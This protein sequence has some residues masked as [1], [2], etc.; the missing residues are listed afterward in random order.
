MKTAILFLIYNRVETSKQV[1]E[2][3]KK[4]EP[5]RL[6]I[7]GDGPKINKEGDADNVKSVRELVLNGITW[8]CEV[9]TL[10]HDSNL[11]CKKAVDGA[12]KWF[13]TKEKQGIIL[14]DDC[15]PLPFFFTFCEKLLGMY[16]N[17]KRIASITGY[18]LCGCYNCS[19]PED[20][21][22]FSS[23]FSAWGWASWRDRIHHADAEYGYDGNID[24]SI[25]QKAGFKEK[26]M[27]KSNLQLL[28]N[29]S[30]NT[31]DWP[32]DFCF[33]KHNMVTIV[34]SKNLIENIG[35]GDHATHTNNDSR[36]SAPLFPDFTPEIN[37]I[38]PSKVCRGYIH[39]YINKRYHS[40][41]HLLF[42]LQKRKILRILNY[43]N[44]K[45]NSY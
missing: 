42:S 3:I 1:L 17:D 11:G 21:F 13:F 8:K 33:R 5:E 43:I 30:V 41:L 20:A 29:N 18:N 2:A 16:K 44:I 10:F 36:K 32:Y 14:E 9:K 19:N 22:F 7:A 45:M 15:L 31:W 37:S 6:Y 40:I 34:P 28:K 12:V 25:F 4:A 23:K 27:L 24:K 26:L 39:H 35:F 38:T